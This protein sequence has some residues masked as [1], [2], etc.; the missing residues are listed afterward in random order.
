MTEECGAV[1]WDAQITVQDRGSGLK[2][3]AT[4]WPLTLPTALVH[5][6]SHFNITWYT[7]KEGIYTKHIQKAMPQTLILKNL[8]SW[9]TASPPPLTRRTCFSQEI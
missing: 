5:H 9:T 6:R 4:D 8:T 2:R 3:V 1:E 7:Q